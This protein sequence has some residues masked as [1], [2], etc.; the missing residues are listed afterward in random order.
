MESSMGF[1]FLK[2]FMG[3]FMFNGNLRGWEFGKSSRLFL[4]FLKRFKIFKIES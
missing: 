3:N 1:R 4:K 2:V